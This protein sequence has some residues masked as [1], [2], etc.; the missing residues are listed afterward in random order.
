MFLQ[1]HAQART[2]HAARKQIADVVPRMA[3]DDV[4]AFLHRAHGKG[5]LGARAVGAGA[6]GAPAVLHELIGL[7]HGF[8]GKKMLRDE[9]VEIT[10]LKV[11][12]VG[13]GVS[14]KMIAEAL[15]FMGAVRNERAG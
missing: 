7:L 15:Q 10:G 6:A 12:I 4:R 5:Q 8:G 1:S 11:G 13:L 9:P 3:D 14:G 2:G